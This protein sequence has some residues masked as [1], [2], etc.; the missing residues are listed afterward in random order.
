VDP[1]AVVHD[2]LEATP[3]PASAAMPLPHQQSTSDYVYGTR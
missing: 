2:V 3:A 1:A